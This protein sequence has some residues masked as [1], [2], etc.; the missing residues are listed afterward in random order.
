MGSVGRLSG[1]CGETVWSVLGGCLNGVGRLSECVARLTVWCGE[2][3]N[4][5][6]RL[7]GERGEAVWTMWGRVTGVHRQTVWMF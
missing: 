3:L 2:T 1:Q 4:V 5:V 7:S 6:G